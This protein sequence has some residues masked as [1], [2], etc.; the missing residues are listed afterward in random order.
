M[1]G[2]EVRERIQKEGKSELTLGR[3]GIK[4]GKG[5]RKG[6]RGRRDRP[7]VAGESLEPQTAAALTQE[8]EEPGK[9]GSEPQSLKSLRRGEAQG[10][11]FFLK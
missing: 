4:Q 2:A 6:H 11:F 1:R 10:F 7:E 8:P 3:C 5:V 9:R